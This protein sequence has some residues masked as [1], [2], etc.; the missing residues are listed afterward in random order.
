M[1]DI[2]VRRGP[3]I[4]KGVKEAAHSSVKNLPVKKA[5]VEK[6]LNQQN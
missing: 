1:P 6:K 4:F 2:A 3:L 5:S